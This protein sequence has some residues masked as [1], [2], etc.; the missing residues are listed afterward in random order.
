MDIYKFKKDL[1]NY[2]INEIK[3]LACF[4]NIENVTGNNL[5]WLIALQNYNRK[6]QFQTGDNIETL[7][8]KVQPFILLHNISTNS[9]TS[10]TKLHT[11]LCT[12][13]QRP[14]YVTS[15]ETYECMFGNVSLH[16][17]VYTE[18]SHDDISWNLIELDNGVSILV[19]SWIYNSTDISVGIGA[20]RNIIQKYANQYNIDS[21]I[22]IDGN[23]GPLVSI[24]RP[25]K[26]CTNVK[27]DDSKRYILYADALR[28]CLQNN[29]IG[30]GSFPLIGFAKASQGEKIG[31]CENECR[32]YKFL[33]QD[34]RVLR[35][36]NQLLY[37]PYMLFF[38]E[39]LDYSRQVLNEQLKCFKC[40]AFGT[41]L[42]KDEYNKSYIADENMINMLKQE[43][44]K[45]YVEKCAS[46]HY[47]SK[48]VNIGA[49]RNMYTHYVRFSR[50]I[51]ILPQ[52]V[53]IAEVGNLPV[54]R[55]I[56]DVTSL[57]VI[58][59][60]GR[61]KNKSTPKELA[62][63][64]SAGTFC[65]IDRTNTCKVID[66]YTLYWY[67]TFLYFTIQDYLEQHASYISRL[68]DNYKIN[69]RIIL[70]MLFTPVEE[71]LIKIVNDINITRLL[72]KHFESV[73]DMQDIET[74]RTKFLNIWKSA[75]RDYEHG[76][77]YIP[78]AGSEFTFGG[79]SDVLA[80]DELSEDVLSEDELAED[81]LAEDVLSED[82]LSEDEY[83]VEKIT[84]HRVTQ[85]KT[86]YY[87]KWKGYDSS[88]NTWE[89]EENILDKSVIDDYM[90]RQ[91]IRKLEHRTISPE[92]AETSS[93]RQRSKRK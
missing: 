77:G 84:D 89:P 27:K 75:K 44:W 9:F 35:R 67:Y 73:P 87:I 70:E 23:V 72:Q 41:D 19:F 37:N 15:K 57:F 68:P 83:I 90:S 13:F 2:T 1:E 56:V 8:P 64:I 76:S 29:C 22:T 60:P 46:E 7:L 50:N 54:L 45:K 31:C 49:Y 69:L 59:V 33:Y 5:L 18:Y 74:K 48:F 65:K 79:F 20:K 25:N 3:L 66:K 62:T 34:M 47:I 42:R 88:E 93:K 55:V 91:N 32:L 58:N 51:N 4:Y 92:H 78:A 17:V 53:W 10:L 14:I 61:G 28:K 71:S 82:E 26:K 81:V 40:P 63:I 86:E 12:G 6:A 43:P 16:K 80:E 21:I 11:Y 38:G 85:N 52:D 30:Y 24:E 36:Y 39:D